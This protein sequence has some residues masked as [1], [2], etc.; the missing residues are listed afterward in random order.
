ME[1]LSE[2]GILSSLLLELEDQCL[3]SHLEWL[4]DFPEDYR[5]SAWEEIP[6]VSVVLSGT[7]LLKMLFSFLLRSNLL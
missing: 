1:V 6:A 2:C 5:D 7:G 4:Y 3:L